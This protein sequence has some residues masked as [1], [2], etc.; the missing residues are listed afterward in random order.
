[1]GRS[2][3]P[4]RD[5]AGRSPR[6]ASPAV[7]PEPWQHISPVLKGFRVTLRE[8]RSTDAVGLLSAIATNEVARFISP[9][10]DTVD[11]FEQF[12]ARARR[13]R[14]T[15]E[16]ICFGVLTAGYAAPVGLFQVRRNEPRCTIAEWG[17]ALGSEFWGEGLFYAAA[18]LVIDWVFE[19]LGAL[20]LEARSATTNGRGN[21]ALH[22]L[23]A[24]QEAVLRRSLLRDGEYFDQ[25]L[26]TLTAERWHALRPGKLNVH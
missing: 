16:G 14:A 3:R 2:Q 8:L 1:M 19:T 13:Q 6:P 18:P 9:P 22:K 24:V 25:A 11:G 23:G 20:R 7:I 5:N 21:G 12:I 10:P 4:A 17:F 26:W 15:G